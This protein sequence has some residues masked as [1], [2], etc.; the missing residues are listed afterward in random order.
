MHKQTYSE[1]AK[2]YK[3]SIRTVQKRLDEYI[4]PIPLLVPKAIILLIDT[5]YF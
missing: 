5:T 2:A 1:L 3:I 4:V